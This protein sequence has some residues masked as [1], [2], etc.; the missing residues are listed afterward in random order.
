VY[1]LAAIIITLALILGIEN[2]QHNNAPERIYQYDIKKFEPDN[3]NDIVIITT[4]QKKKEVVYTVKVSGCL[5]LINGILDLNNLHIWPWVGGT[6]R[7]SFYLQEGD[8]LVYL[9]R[10]ILRDCIIDEIT[11]IE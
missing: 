10:L 7:S 2:N 3:K 1:T 6:S 9:D 5:D 4:R 11:K 8:R